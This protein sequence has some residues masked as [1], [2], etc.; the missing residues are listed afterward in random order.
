MRFA[1]PLSRR[2]SIHARRVRT[3]GCTLMMVLAA[4]CTTD[5]PTSGARGVVQV[6][7]ADGGNQCGQKCSLSIPLATGASAYLLIH[8]R[9][10]LPRLEVVS[11]DPDVLALESTSLG[12]HLFLATG[13]RAGTATVRFED[14]GAVVDE[15]EV[16]V[17][18]PA[19]FDAID[20][21]DAVGE[22]WQPVF[23]R[24]RDA[25]GSELRGFGAVT[26]EASDAL[27]VRSPDGWRFERFFGLPGASPWPGASAE[28]FEVRGD[29]SGS[30]GFVRAILPAG[31]TELPLWAAAPGV[32]ELRLT[33]DV[34]GENA[35][36][37]EARIAIATPDRF[38][39]CCEW[40]VEHD[41]AS[42]SVRVE[43]CEALVLAS[44]DTTVAQAATVVCEYAGSRQAIGVTIAALP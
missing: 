22:V 41:D 26:Y 20:A 7:W 28:R 15:V 24:L 34:E 27:D 23:A 31:P 16:E 17:R 19:R 39:P 32:R 2:E 3:A 38:A 29:A 42:V 4:G 13:L 8:N 6:A 36:R 37:I 43:Q 11:A 25:S 18:D 14:E 10:D 9:P 35:V 33:S 21:P 30:P 1:M 5:G 12:D 40:T 44:T